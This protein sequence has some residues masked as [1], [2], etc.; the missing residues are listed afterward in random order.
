MNTI[1]F[2]QL[3][4]QLRHW[5]MRCL[6]YN[7]VVSL[8]DY[9]IQLMPVPMF[10]G[11]PTTTCENVDNLMKLM[12]NKELKIEAIKAYRTLT[13]AGLKEAKDAVERYW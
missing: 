9:I 12:V 13:N 10:Q 6:E 4:N 1:K 7:E 5:G 2:G 8:H 11:T 3:I